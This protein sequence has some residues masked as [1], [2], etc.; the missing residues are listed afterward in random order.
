LTLYD[1]AFG[2]NV[3]SPVNVCIVFPP[4][5]VIVPPDAAGVPE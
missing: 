2:I 1:K 5:C 3:P 4:D